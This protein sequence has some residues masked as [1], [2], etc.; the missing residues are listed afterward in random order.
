MSVNAVR[1]DEDILGLRRFQDTIEVHYRGLKALGVQEEVYSTIVVPLIIEKLPKDLRLNITRGSQFLEWNVKDVLTSLQKELELRE[2]I[3]RTST[4]KEVPRR[5]GMGVQRATASAFLTE[6]ADECPF[7]LGK[8]EAKDCMKV[9]TAKERK[10]SLRKYSRCF[11]CLKKNHRFRSCKVNVTCSLCGGSHNAAL[12]EGGAGPSPIG[13]SAASPMRVGEQ[14]SCVAMQTAQALVRGQGECRARVF[15]D[16]GS[17][18]S[19]VATRLKEQINPKVRRKEWLELTTFGNTSSKKSGL[20]DVA[21]FELFSL[22][23]GKGIKVEAYVVPYISSVRSMCDDSI[24]SSYPHLQG[25]YFSDSK[26]SVNDFEVTILIGA[27]Y[28]WQFQNGCVI[29]GRPNEP[30]A[31]Q[32]SLG[33]VLSGPIKG[34]LSEIPTEVTQIN[35]VDAKVNQVEGE[36]RKLWDL[37]TIGIRPCD[38][39]T[40]NFFDDVS[41][42]GVRYSVR[43][44]W[45]TGHDSLPT[46]YNNSLHRLKNLLVKLSNDPYVFGECQKVIDEQ[47]KA[48]I[49]EKVSNLDTYDDCH[50]LPH[51]PV[52]RQQA[53]TTKVRIVY[54]A[55]SKAGKGTAS[56]NDCLHVGP[57]LNP[58]LYDILIRFRMGSIV[59]TAD[60]EKAFLNIEVDKQDRDYLRF[61]WCPNPSDKDPNIEVYRF[62][63]V[64]FGVNSSPFL[65]NATLKHHLQNFK[66]SD[67]LFVSQ[68]QDSLYVDDMV[69]STNT[70]EAARDMY[71]KARSRMSSGGFKL[72]K[73]LSNHPDLEHEIVEKEQHIS[74]GEITGDTQTAIANNEDTPLHK[75]LGLEW[76]V[77]LDTVLFNFELTIDKVKEMKPSKREILSA[78][79]GVFDPLGLISPLQVGVKVLFQQLCKEKVGW[80]DEI[81]TIFKIRWHNWIEGMK[82]VRSIS[83]DRFVLRKVEQ[84]EKD[85]R[86]TLHGFCDA[87]KDAYCAAIYVVFENGMDKQVSL[88]TSKIRV[89]PLKTMTIPRLELMGARI[90]AS[91][92][93][94]VKGAIKNHIVITEC[95]YWTD[96]LTVMYWL[97]NKGEWKQFV[98]SRVSEILTS[99][100]K[101][102]WRHCPGSKNP[103]DIG[104]RG[105]GAGQLKDNELWWE[106]PHFL[107]Q[108]PSEWPSVPGHLQVADENVER[109]RKA[110]S[111]AVCGKEA[112]NVAKLININAYSN[113]LKLLRVTAYV[114]RFLRNLRTK[115]RKGGGVIQG[116]SKEE[117]S[118]AETL[119]FQSI[120]AEMKQQDNYKQLARELG[121][122]ERDGMLR[123]KG[124]LSRSDLLYE[125]VYPLLL[126][127]NHKFT[128]MVVVEGHKNVHHSGVGATL[129]EVRLRYWIPRGKQYVKAIINKCV[130]CTRE[131]G[132]PYDTPVPAELPEFRV[133][134]A[135]PFYNVGVDFAGPLLIK[136]DQGMI[137]SYI[138][139]FTCAVTRAVHLELVS[140]MGAQ[141]FLNCFRRFTARRGTP[142]IVIS[143]NAQTFKT[144]GMN[145]KELYNHPEVRAELDRKGVE[146][147]LEWKYILERAPNWGGFYER[148]IGMTK[149]C[150]K[151]VL[152]NA[153]LSY[154]E[155]H[156][157][158]VEIEGTLN[159]RPLSYVEGEPYDILTPSHLL[160]G[161]NIRS[162]PDIPLEDECYMQKDL[163]KRYKYLTE[164]LAHFW[165]RWKKEYL[166]NLRE[167]HRNLKGRGKKFVAIGD[168]VLLG[169]ESH[170]K[171]NE[172]K[173]GVVQDLIIGK[174]GEARGASVRIAGKKKSII[175]SRAVGKLFPLE[176]RSDIEETNEGK[177]VEELAPA[178]SDA[179][180][181]RPPHRAAAM[182]STWKTHCM[183]DSG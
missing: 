67:S 169:D 128:E 59:L 115:G 33:W 125:S 103:A 75:I 55:S 147:V 107:K 12:C 161:R 105:M 9:R 45:K 126:P 119:W 22:A 110:T 153:R 112:Q 13:A 71:E 97:Q 133:R 143:D 180:H 145:L 39:V 64:V 170:K 139:L 56:L 86:C 70:L 104:S 160:F 156:T 101:K 29:R 60:I 5:T 155:L 154:D 163:G 89:S 95:F 76:N 149:R 100:H 164:R 27:D 74:Q 127:R 36:L 93:S 14:E 54:D 83:V 171:R 31:I 26:S 43:L 61:L 132:T 91:L 10:N 123:V 3:A 124:R 166:L 62:C 28:L 42:N 92:M 118:H 181:T 80:D 172:W 94:T 57:S 20:T 18:K 52:V 32:T 88:L 113:R 40:E 177:Q 138:A 162:L 79:A 58:L 1:D 49:I 77:E 73:W 21:E 117:I 37:E 167:Q 35:R 8:H 63:R 69:F 175:L 183:L 109:E 111:L 134:E 53:K 84:G 158:L 25:L 11:N 6:K 99:S 182:D 47:L 17:N 157:I 68:M 81:E 51:R 116:L 50:Y 141:S 15:F 165:I 2:E 24:Q 85:Y 140:D 108:S 66:D 7:C 65:L 19:F 87:S 16:S 178:P 135:P 106:G 137:K 151:R 41:F 78:L 102:Q 44:P 136:S 114:L 146:W 176:V 72:R 174:D 122:F 90:L 129:G 152:G 179:A 23:G 173:L 131:K 130:R 30:V 159:A 142:A 46:N 82:K 121:V 48:G 4:K 150:L 120:Q 96:S 144:T 38:E 148:L 168:V 34:K 98:R